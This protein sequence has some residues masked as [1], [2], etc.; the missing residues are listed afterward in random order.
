MT[1]I[2][3]ASSLRH[4]LGYSMGAI[5]IIAP[6]MAL[7]MPKGMAPLFALT[8]VLG[9]ACYAWRHRS[10]PSVSRKY[11][12]VFL[13]LI[14][15]G[16]V[17]AFWSVSP[18]DTLRIVAPLAAT[19]FGGLLLVSLMA[20]FEDIEREIFNRLLLI[21]VVLGFVLLAFEIATEISLT[22]FLRQI[23]TGQELVPNYLYLIYISQG[24]VICTLFL[25][26]VLLNLLKHGK[27]YRASALALFAVSTLAFSGN[28]S[29][30]VALIVGFGIFGYCFIIP[31]IANRVIIGFLVFMI[32]AAPIIP[33]LIPNIQD[34]GRRVSF[35][36][37]SAYPR[38]FIWQYAADYISED[39][40]LGKGLN[41]SRALHDKDDVVSFY[42]NKPGG[43]LRT[44]EPIPLHPHNGI[45]QIWLE[46]GLVGASILMLFLVMIARHIAKVPVDNWMR[47]GFYATF[48][49]GLTIAS[50]SYG[51]WQSWW[52]S[53]LWLTTAFTVG[54]G[55]NK[56]N[57]SAPLDAEPSL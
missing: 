5:A 4:C 45:L 38:I 37:H 44:S 35:L 14:V 33:R 26:P 2:T 52:L 36:P 56:S 21:G 7:F 11:A 1:Q 57:N 30:F 41:S 39:P 8:V 15:F 32:A 48:F 23:V 34:L 55:K 6:S 12:S 28:L 49:I 22:R 31:S 40:I 20:K 43:G 16:I 27:K 10:L 13:A 47:A 25:C 19:L 18:K 17:S 24:A 54:V 50:I 9:V 51:I 42:I 3:L 29:S 46:L 53:T